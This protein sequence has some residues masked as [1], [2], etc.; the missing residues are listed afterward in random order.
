MEI[1]RGHLIIAAL[2]DP[3]G[4]PPSPYRLHVMLKERRR[5]RLLEDL[6]LAEDGEHSIEINTIESPSLCSSGEGLCS[7]RGAK[8]FPA[9]TPAICRSKRTVHPQLPVRW[10]KKEVNQRT[11]LCQN[12]TTVLSIVMNWIFERLHTE[13]K[14]KSQMTILLRS[15]A[16]YFYYRSSR[17]P[18]GNRITTTADTGAR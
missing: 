11:A 6:R 13:S 18:D 8:I 9:G 7:A 15:K 16:L 12:T 5:R 17:H 4:Y 10:G 14:S 3:C 2:W 1:S